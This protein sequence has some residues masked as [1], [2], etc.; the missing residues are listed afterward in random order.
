MLLSCWQHR[1]FLYLGK[2]WWL[3]VN[4]SQPWE[5]LAAMHSDITSSYPMTSL[6]WASGNS[7]HMIWSTHEN[8]KCLWRPPPPPAIVDLDIIA[9]AFWLLMLTLHW[10]LILG[11]SACKSNLACLLELK[12]VFL[13]SLHMLGCLINI[14]KRLPDSFFQGKHNVNANDYIF[15]VLIRHWTLYKSYW[16]LMKP[17]CIVEAVFSYSIIIFYRSLDANTV[18]HTFEEHLKIRFEGIIFVQHVTL[19]AHLYHWFASLS[20]NLI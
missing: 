19:L 3:E 16:E 10:V 14:C 13:L 15:P 18:T 6:D 20:I 2:N 7:S 5:G 11:Y 9:A 8:G 1:M 12:M 4:D 17:D